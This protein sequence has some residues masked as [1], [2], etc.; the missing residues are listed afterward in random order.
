M[1]ICPAG[2]TLITNPDSKVRGKS[3][4]AKKDACKV[5][6]SRSKCNGSK[7]EAGR[8]IRVDQFEK[9][10]QA[11]N[12]KMETTGSKAIYKRRKVI[13][14]PPL[15]HIKESEVQSSWLKRLDELSGLRA[16]KQRQFTVGINSFCHH[17]RTEPDAS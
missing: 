13:T 17:R 8:V 5:C 14:E 10:C 2:E 3:Y 16:L 1:F 11:M 6:L 9:A 7:K 15:G 4:R 12:K